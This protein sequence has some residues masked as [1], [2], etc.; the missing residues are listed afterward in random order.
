[1]LATKEKSHPGFQLPTAVLHPGF[2]VAIS[3]TATEFDAAS[4]DFRSGPLCSGYFRDAETQ[5]DYADQRYHQPGMGRFLTP[6]PF[7][8]SEVPSI[9]GSWNRYAYVANDPINWNDPSGLCAVGVAGLNMWLGSNPSFENF[10]NGVGAVTAYPYANEGTIAGAASVVSQ[11]AFGPNDSTETA[12][13]ALIYALNTNSG[14]IDVVAY[15][16]GAQAFSTAY[17]Q[18]TPSRRGLE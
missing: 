3:N 15:S 4:Y 9:P 14:L 8:G 1:M 7:M 11:A 12:L 10:A 2:G 5:L 13:A 16:G 18:L 6:D 17:E